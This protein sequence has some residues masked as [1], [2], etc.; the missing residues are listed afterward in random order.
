MTKDSE[1]SDWH[2]LYDDRMPTF[3]RL[4]SEVEHILE[5]VLKDIKIHD[6]RVR[7]KKK[8]SFLEKIERKNYRDPFVEMTDI[9]GS[10][11]VCLFV[12]D[13]KKVESI[14]EREFSIIERNDKL[15]NLKP[16]TFGY[17]S[18][19][20]LC[21]FKD[22]YRGP[23]YEGL[24]N[25]VF[26]VQLR[27]IL[28]DAWAVVEHTL[29]YKGRVSTPP[30]LRRDFSAL[31]GLLH[32][33]DKT[34]QYIHDRGHDLEDA[35]K[36]DVSELMNRFNSGGPSATAD[37]GID[38]NTLKAF[39]IEQFPDRIQSQA[40]LYSAFAD[41]L[42]EIGVTGISQLRKLVDKHLDDVLEQEREVNK[43][44]KEQRQ[45]S[46]LGM[47]RVITSLEY[48]GRGVRRVSPPTPSQ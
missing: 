28:Q 33:A 31:A 1:K 12:D 14:I 18:V 20:Y 6:I 48:P 5:M 17:Q 19:H 32:V 10:R 29:A 34:F 11:V 16:E 25:L 15:D 30:D 37:I 8:E 46:G 22:G 4:R 9:V 43:E 26:E 27:T 3:V 7:V 2:A 41:E 44:T 24:H 39:L 13:I 35:A 36:R 38:R 42:G 40:R 21:K 23:R 47:L 45:L